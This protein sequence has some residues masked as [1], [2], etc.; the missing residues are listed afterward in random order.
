MTKPTMPHV[1]AIGFEIFIETGL[2]LAAATSIAI[3]YVKPDGT[4]GAFVAVAASKAASRSNTR[5]GARYVTTAATDLDQFGTW[6]LQVDA[7][8]PSGWDGPGHV[9]DMEVG[10]AL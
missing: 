3:N 4:T 10:P 9:A 2:D 6:Q 7:T 8:L 1:G 5:Y